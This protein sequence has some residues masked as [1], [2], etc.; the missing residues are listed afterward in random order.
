MLNYYGVNV[1][2]KNFS[3]E[4]ITEICRQ[5]AISTTPDYSLHVSGENMII[6]FD[7]LCK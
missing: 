3:P 4:E 5:K 1:S 6:S 2:R 7:T